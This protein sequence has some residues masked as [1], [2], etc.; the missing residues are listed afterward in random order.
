MLK[1]KG[2][3]LTAENNL[4]NRKRFFL[5][6]SA[7]FAIMSLFV[8]FNYIEKDLT[9]VRTG[10]G[11]WQHYTVLEYYG[12]WLRSIVYALFREH[13][14]V[15][16]SWDFSI[17]MGSDILTTFNYYIIGDP[18]TLLSA[19]V[20]VK[21]TPYLFNFLS[22]LRYYLSGI[23]FALF[24]FERKH[25]SGTGVM[26]GAFVYIFG[27][28]A[29]FAGT[30]HPYFVNAMI[31]LPILL[32]CVERILKNRN[33][34]YL[35]L[36]VCIAEISNFYF[37]YVLVI[38]TVVYV[39][40][41]LFEIYKTDIRAMIAPLFRI[42]ASSVIGVIMGS[43][44][45][46]P[47]VTRL[48]SD[49]RMSIDTSYPFLHPLSYYKSLPGGLVSYDYCGASTYL[50]YSV[51]ILFAL[52]ALFTVKKK[53]KS[54]KIFLIICAAGFATPWFASFANG[55][56]YPTNRWL[57]TFSLALAF[58]VSACWERIFR[59]DKK[60]T[61]IIAVVPLV[62][63]ALC[64]LSDHTEKKNMLIST[65]LIV[66]ISACL[67]F[68]RFVRVKNVNIKKLVSSAVVVVSLLSV[69]VN[70]QFSFENLSKYFTVGYINTAVTKDTVAIKKQSKLDP[71]KGFYR[72]TGDELGVNDNVRQ[73]MNNTQQ[74]WSLS[75]G[76]VSD[77]HNAV[78]LNEPY[79]QWV[80][81]FD[82]ITS[83]N[84]L[85][86]VKYYYDA[87]NKNT[88]IPYGYIETET[89]NVYLNTN[90]LPLGYTY[91]SFIS[92]E[93]FD[94]LPTSLAKQQAMLQG[95][96][97]EETTDHCKSADAVFDV[98][99]IDKKLIIDS[100]DVTLS[101]NTF[102]VTKNGAKVYF[103][104]EP[105]ENSELYVSLKDISYIGTD[106]YKLYTDDTDVDPKNLY[107]MD[108]FY[109]LEEKEQEKLIFNSR[110]FAEKDE[111]GIKVGTLDADKKLITRKEVMYFTPKF[112]FYCG[113]SSFDA[114]LGYSEEGCY[115]ISIE[116]PYIG[117]Y[118][119]S[120]I[121]FYSQT[122][123]I[124]E[125]SVKKLSE[126]TLQNVTVGT[127]LIKGSITV[128]ENKLLCLSIPYTKGWTAY[129]D[130]VETELVKANIM[131]MALELDEGEHEIEL[132]YSTPNLK[133]GIVIS[134]FGF[135]L[136]FAYGMWY[137][138]KRNKNLSKQTAKRG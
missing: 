80:N 17:G 18:L 118:T 104:I 10:D 45:F 52:V 106:K 51:I 76:A 24:C 59:A 4:I 130:G 72:Y 128:S 77:F 83:V 62:Y 71:D 32:I 46:V 50:G 94:S 75:N 98:K 93:A 33:P 55:F 101:G 26:V 138:I 135:M 47:V 100:D 23:F 58:T 126:E 79:Y 134:V 42:A 124:Y 111:I 81:G 133:A 114:N 131:F 67:I 91:N 107:N 16:P 49:S 21:Y 27:S 43:A 82:E 41:R 136:I 37:F 97:L 99:K 12:K 57:F 61:L 31:Y 65:G 84:T 92:R 35:A 123:D 3:L 120:D 19:L 116:F 70:A 48:L 129:V 13:K 122:M 112:D 44:I 105:Q 56:S 1:S 30:K 34:I 125:Q 115:Y 108:D 14:L 109:A 64:F 96:I 11:Y 25:K 20:P 113:K 38:A 110:Y 2:T 127:D 6:Y 28:F 36:I 69:V 15:I 137:Y 60:R 117:K 68:N 5:I 74:Y 22:I 78:S 7:L 86:S 8:F 85:S 87:D 89:E 121:S 88:N 73:R 132:R 54:E 29:L 39:L 9:F 103:E 63:A 66:I 40:V 90:Y 53:N 102:T 119:F 95:V